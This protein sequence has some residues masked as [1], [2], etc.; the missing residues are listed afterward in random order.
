[1]F[2]PSTSMS[3]SQGL[4]KGGEIGR[5]DSRLRC[6]RHPEVV[7]LCWCTN[8]TRW[9]TR[10]IASCCARWCTTCT[11][12]TAPSWALILLCWHCCI[13][14][15]LLS[16]YLYVCLLRRVQLVSLGWLVRAQFAFCILYFV[17]CILYCA[18]RS[19]GVDRWGHLCSTGSF[20][21]ET[22]NPALPDLAPLPHSSWCAG[23][24][25]W[26]WSWW[27]LSSWSFKDWEREDG[28]ENETLNLL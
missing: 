10:W 20:H 11:R 13:T 19:S 21:H 5:W 7:S 25:S 12:V 28:G 17:F 18:T 23:S 3:S 9:C 2:D 4:W 16:L 1:M 8:C 14:H 15:F 26:S 22:L 24:S 6:W 27:W